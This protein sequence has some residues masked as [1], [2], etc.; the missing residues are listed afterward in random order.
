[1][2]SVYLDVCCLNRPHDDQS[3][4]RV[5][6][7]TVAVETIIERV[8]IGA[9][10]GVGS[11][12]VRLETERISDA[13]RKTHVQAQANLFTQTVKIQQEQVVRGRRLEELGFK[14][15]DALHIA[16]AEQ[17]QA[18]MLL[19]T[20]DRFMRLASRVQTELFVKVANPVNWLSEVDQ[21]GS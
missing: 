19:T 3:Q 4:E 9:Y 17:G 5:R 1:M 14:T 11:E 2:I 6:L 7:E 18:G 15:L 8:E 12:A 13:E 20:D 21:N 16:C 10:V